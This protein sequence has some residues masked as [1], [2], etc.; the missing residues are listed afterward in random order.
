MPFKLVIS[1]QCTQQRFKNKAEKRDLQVGETQGGRQKEAMHPKC[2]SL[3]ADSQRHHHSYFRCVVHFIAL[4]FLPWCFLLLLEL[5]HTSR[6]E[7]SPTSSLC[8]G[9]SVSFMHASIHPRNSW[10][11]GA[12]LSIRKSDRHSLYSLGVYILVVRQLSNK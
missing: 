5:N 8:F 10:V 9:I 11:L 6:L 7:S 2:P 12:K 4:K 1:V 3:I